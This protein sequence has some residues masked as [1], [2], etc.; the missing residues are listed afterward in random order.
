MLQFY[1]ICHLLLI[2]F[3]TLLINI[4]SFDSAFLANTNQLLIVFFPEIMDKHSNYLL[5]YLYFMNCLSL[6]FPIFQLYYAIF[7]PNYS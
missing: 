4:Q 7:S 1:L 5:L 6:S 3:L 2:E